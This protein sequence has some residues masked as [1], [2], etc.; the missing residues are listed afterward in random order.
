M[1]ALDTCAIIDL[2]KED[3]SLNDL[4]GSLDEEFVSTQIN[5][6]E[7]IFGINPENKK[8]LEE[9]FKINLLFDSIEVFNL[10]NHSIKKASLVKWGLRSKGIIIDS[11]DCLVAGML[12]NNRVDKIITKNVKHFSKIKGLKVLS[13]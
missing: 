6:S 12:L 7:L 9:E 11:F 2:L 5:Y 4:I 1:I 10:D 3:K 13:Y 8:H